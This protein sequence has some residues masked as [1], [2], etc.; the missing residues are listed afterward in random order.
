M[1][2]DISNA[3]TGTTEFVGLEF[4]E[5]GG[6][7]RTS[8]PASLLLPPSSTKGTALV[9][10][11]CPKLRRSNCGLHLAD[12]F[13]NWGSTPSPASRS[14]RVLGPDANAG[15]APDVLDQPY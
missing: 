8:L 7:F 13:P 9:F 2:G 14:Q 10:A 11:G 1:L 3:I 12:T 6:D 5:I 15:G 4:I